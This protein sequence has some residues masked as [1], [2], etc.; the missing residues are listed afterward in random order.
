MEVYAAIDLHASNSFLAVVD[1]E[2]KKVFQRRLVNDSAILLKALEPYKQGMRGI[3]VES[4]FN[5]YW[6]VDAM[7]EAGYRVHLANPAA[8][9]KYSGMKHSNDNSDAVWLAEML[10]LGILPEGYIYPREERPVR[11]LLRKRMHLV[12]LRTSLINSLQNI[13]VRNT[14]AKMGSAKIKQLTHDLVSPLLEQDEH[15]ALTCEVSKQTI[16]F[17]TR[18]I[19]K[20]EKK[21]QGKIK[22]KKEYACLTTIPGVG[23]ILSLTIVLETGPISRFQAA[24][25]YASYCRKV[26]TRW[27]SNGKSKGSGNKKNGN[28]YLAWAFSE[29]SELARRFDPQIKAWFDRKLSKTSRMCAHSALGH[30]LARAAY[31]IMRD[32]VSFDNK[33]LIG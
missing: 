28:K 33:R 8:I 20:V 4:T 13:L 23:V 11:D 7:M 26:P 6:V 3:A 10:R 2:G 9:Q 18:Q 16:D 30:K 24:G 22:L 27:T 15:L 31:Y 17:L 14:G 32:H 21:I 25:N 12:K 1:G 19:K 29:A 5:W